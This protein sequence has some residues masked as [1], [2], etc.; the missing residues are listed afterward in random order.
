MFPL[1]MED[2]IA[3][4]IN[5]LSTD[6][7]EEVSSQES[8]AGK[9]EKRSHSLVEPILMTSYGNRSLSVS[10]WPNNA[11]GLGSPYN[12]RDPINITDIPVK[13]IQELIH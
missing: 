3:D 12:G 13:K 6:S 9:V 10:H 7:K 4:W 8:P 5:W 1:G 11:F 2:F